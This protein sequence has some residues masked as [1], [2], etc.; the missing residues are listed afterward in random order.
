M[1]RISRGWKIIS[2]ITIF[3]Y[4][5]RLGRSSSWKNYQRCKKKIFSF[6]P[7]IKNIFNFFKDI[8]GIVYTIYESIGKSVVV[9]YCGSKT[10][11]VRLTVSPDSKAKVIKSRA[12]VGGGGITSRKYRYKAKKIN[13]NGE[14]NDAMDGDNI[15]IVDMEGVA[16]DSEHIS[17]GNCQSSPKE[18]RVQPHT[19]TS[20]TKSS[21]PITDRQFYLY[22]AEDNHKT[23][24]SNR[25]SKECSSNPPETKE[26]SR[27]TAPQPCCTAVE[28]AQ[29][30]LK[31]PIRTT[32]STPAH[33]TTK[34]CRIENTENNVYE[35][36][37]N[38]K[39]CNGGTP[40]NIQNGTKI[41]ITGCIECSSQYPLVDVSIPA[42]ENPM[43][44]TTPTISVTTS[45]K[46]R[47]FV[48]KSRSKKQKTQSSCH[49]RVRSLSVGNEN[50]Y[51]NDRNLAVENSDACLNNLRRNDLIDIIRESME[52]NRLCF[53]SNG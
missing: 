16:G 14:G 47:K 13:Q 46:T 41:D 2:T 12:S 30:M 37:S 8:A 25:S 4:I 38:F 29:Q 22:I 45:C 1:R 24:S 53:Q 39:C 50:C 18:S 32:T 7:N 20:T 11:N 10:I 3:I 36:I 15:A 42:V 49:A 35:S 52:K 48:L 33:K 21:K 23:D 26:T 9:P 34:T 31:S 44:S 40:T 27:I 6:Y 19:S 51:R 28:T 43:L 17:N 5:L